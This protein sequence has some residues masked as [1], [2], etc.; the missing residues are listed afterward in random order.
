MIDNMDDD[1]EILWSDDQ[2][3]RQTKEGPYANTPLEDDGTDIKMEINM[4]GEKFL[5]KY[6]I[7]RDISKK[8][9]IFNGTY[10][11]SVPFDYLQSLAMS[12]DTRENTS[13]TRRKQTVEYAIDRTF[14]LYIDWNKIKKEEIAFKDGIINIITDEKRPHRWQDYLNNIIPHKYTPN[15][16]CPV[17]NRCLDDWFETDDKKLALQEFF[18]YILLS[19]TAFKKALLLLGESNTGKSVPCEVATMMVGSE[20][21]ASLLPEKMDDP[22]FTAVL[23]NKKL[24]K[25]TEISTDSKIA[26]GGFKQIISGESIQVNEKYVNVEN[27][28][29]TAKHMFATNVLPIITDQSEGVFNRLLIIKFNKVVEKDKQ[30]T[31]LL[32][33]LKEE[34][35]GIVSWAVEGAKRLTNNNGK[36][37]IVE[38]SV[39]LL[40]E[41]RLSQNPILSF[42]ETSGDIEICHEGKILTDEFSKLFQQFK[43]GREY[44]KTSITR[45]IKKLGY[46]CVSKG[47]KRYYTGI[48]PAAKEKPSVKDNDG[49]PF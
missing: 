37:T 1:L 49:M 25:V 36:F 45:Q 48:K 47:G 19:H 34:I 39:Q 5:R 46:D 17:W 12:C 8:I 26:D 32:D 33:K 10:W 29:P 24:N 13:T 16:K 42:I 35:D 11:Q 31:E 22:N 41:Y 30:D 38:E 7:T 20:F 23:K 2:K 9:Y 3:E 15:A 27:I 43:G 4:M 18:G 6:T 14:Q 40:R 21:T 28:V 44:S